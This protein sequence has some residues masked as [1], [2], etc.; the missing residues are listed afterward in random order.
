[1]SLLHQP[2]PAEERRIEREK[3]I[4][5]VA[6]AVN[7]LACVSKNAY[8]KFWSAEPVQL[9]ADLN[10]NLS[11]SLATMQANS[12]VAAAVNAQLDLINLE[13]Y[14][15]RIPSA[16]PDHITFDSELGQFIYTAPVIEEP[17]IEPEA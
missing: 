13:N 17:E 6:E 2:S 15:T 5:T 10:E 16:L 8:E 1:M 7:N 4:L 11:A 9:V 3:I 12:A 14:S